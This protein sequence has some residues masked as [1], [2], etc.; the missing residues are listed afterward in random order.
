MWSVLVDWLVSAATSGQINIPGA[1]GR[2]GPYGL[3]SASSACSDMCW[4]W[5]RA[6]S[7]QGGR[8]HPF[9]P[10]LSHLF[11]GRVSEGDAEAGCFQ[12]CFWANQRIFA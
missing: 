1:V 12:A 3:L 2:L 7:K 9:Y 11:A 6:S 8:K 4:A 10:L 5:T